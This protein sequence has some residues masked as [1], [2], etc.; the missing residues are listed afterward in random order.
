MDMANS[1]GLTAPLTKE[2]SVRTRYVDKVTMSGPT[3]TS[4]GVLGKQEKCMDKD[5][6]HNPMGDDMLENSRM[7][8]RKAKV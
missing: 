2:T 6:I 7:I 4:I 8:K 3:G 1:L 5:N